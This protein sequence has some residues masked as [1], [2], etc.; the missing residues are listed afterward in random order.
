MSTI[1]EV[2]NFYYHYYFKIIIK[3]GAEDFRWTII[4]LFDSSPRLIK[5]E[6]IS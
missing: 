3:Y 6:I 5:Q 4:D 1:R 2:G